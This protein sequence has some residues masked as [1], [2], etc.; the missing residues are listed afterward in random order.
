MISQ[1]LSVKGEGY[2]S[3][4]ALSSEGTR[5]REDL[6]SNWAEGIHRYN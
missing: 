4:I 5:T 1:D 6:V 2:R 3:R